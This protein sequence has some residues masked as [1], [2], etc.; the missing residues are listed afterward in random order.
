MENENNS[1]TN[2]CTNPCTNT[3]TNTCT[4]AT[5]ENGTATTTSNTHK[6]VRTNKD[7]TTIIDGKKES[8]ASV[9]KDLEQ[10]VN[11][12]SVEESIN[13]L[14]TAISTKDNSIIFNPLQAGAKEFEER[15]GRPMTYS[16]MREMWG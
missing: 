9:M 16:E 8:L 2:T 12:K 13:M 3:C 1:Y 15:V 10:K 7:D 4:G 5:T 11:P 6:D 14:A